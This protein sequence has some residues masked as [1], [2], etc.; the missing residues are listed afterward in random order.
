MSTNT[1]K[2]ESLATLEDVLPLDETTLIGVF[3]ADDVLAALIRYPNGD[4]AKLAQGEMS[5]VGRVAAIKL[6]AIYLTNKGRKRVLR[7]P[8]TDTRAQ[9]L[10]A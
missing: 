9:M 6:D 4:I 8:E 7:L 5:R 10:G 1:S 3:G 2:A